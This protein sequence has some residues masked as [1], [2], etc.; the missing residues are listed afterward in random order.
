MTTTPAHSTHLQAEQTRE[1]EQDFLKALAQAD[2]AFD[3]YV[4]EGDMYGAAETLCS[5]TIT[6][7]HLADHTGTPENGRA[8][9]LLQALHTAQASV[10]IATKHAVSVAIPY[11]NL[12]KVQS[13][14]GMNDE[15]L[16]SYQKAVEEQSSRPHH[17][18]NRPGVLANFQEILASAQLAMGDTSALERAER[19]LQD[20]EASDEDDYNKAV[21][22]LHGHARIAR[23]CSSFNREA[24]QKHYQ[25]AQAIFSSRTDLALSK[26]T[27][28]ELKDI[29]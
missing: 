18:Q 24:A 9:Y 27:L 3:S 7:R 29:A 4:Q 6:L 1:H 23:A 22:L 13:E 5:R 14:L 17:T 21:W 19:A 26:K 10:A 8:S 16:E 15:A 28:D 25:A 12:G 11:L 2:E 20:L